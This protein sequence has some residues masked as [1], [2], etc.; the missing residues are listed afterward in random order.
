MTPLFKKVAS[1]N[2]RCHQI[3]LTL[4]VTK[5]DNENMDEQP[6]KRE[7]ISLKMLPTLIAAIE[8]LAASENRSRSNMIEVLLQEALAAR[9]GKPKK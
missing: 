6:G 1:D 8:K 9:E 2:T 7:Y 4:G 5:C 3:L